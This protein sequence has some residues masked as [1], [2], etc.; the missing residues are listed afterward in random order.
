MSVTS[1]SGLLLL[2]ACQGGGGAATAGAV[3]PCGGGGTAPPPGACGL[4]CRAELPVRMQDGMPMVTVWLGAQPANLLLD[5]GA[6]TSDLTTDGAKRLGF[7]HTTAVPGHIWG[8][9]GDQGV[10]LVT[11]PRLA[12]GEVSLDALRLPVLVMGR[13][14]VETLPDGGLGDDILHRYE[15]DLD[16]PHDVVRLY[17]GRPCP[18]TLPGWTGEDAA[19][20]WTR[21]FASNWQVAVPA[22]LDGHEVSAM[23][24]S[25]A[26]T[27]VVGMPAALAAGVPPTELASDLDAKMFGV[28]P[29]QVAGKLHRFDSVV[30]GGQT[31]P[32]L[33]T[34][35]VALPTTGFDMVL[36]ADYLQTHKVWISYATGQVHVAHSW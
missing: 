8:I 14:G 3:V 28:G 31:V 13:A 6:S 4:V 15:V 19:L 34:A 12:F 26:A 16:F 9:G 18:G 2:A 27:T 5:T 23:I 30:V 25:G 35:V 7:E 33:E 17:A 11:L 21:P 36:G 22:S 32:D 1:L 10:A 29:G 20:P 24:D